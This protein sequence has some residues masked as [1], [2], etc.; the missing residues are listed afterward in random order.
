MNKTITTTIILIVFLTGCANSS[1][2][3]RPTYVSPVAYQS[4][5]C[6]QLAAESQHIQTRVSQLGGRLDG[7]TTHGK[8][9]DTSKTIFCPALYA[10]GRTKQQDTDYALMKG[11]YNAIQ[12]ESKS[13]KCNLTARVPVP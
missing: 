8:E 7:A 3:I 6:D 2:D 4:F 5:D 13:K 11:Q 12:Q 9:L 1:N 10:L